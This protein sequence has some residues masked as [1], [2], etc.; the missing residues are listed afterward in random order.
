M[1]EIPQ[2]PVKRKPSPKSSYFIRLRRP[3]SG[4]E[5][6]VVQ[7]W[8]LSRDGATESG[9]LYGTMFSDE[10]DRLAE[11]LGLPIEYETTE[12][13]IDPLKAWPVLPADPISATKFDGGANL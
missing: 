9:R 1:P 5:N 2:L 6:S 4:D 8:V 7:L 3:E 11:L 10:A 13:K 12:W